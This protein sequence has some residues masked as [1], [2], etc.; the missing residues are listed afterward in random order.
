LTTPQ[1]GG[2]DGQPDNALLLYL[3]AILGLSAS[4]GT[5]VIGVI[6][7]KVDDV[8]MLVSIP[9]LVLGIAGIAA[10]YYRD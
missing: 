10:Y 8:V 4:F 3:F 2:S 6:L 7:G 1:S 9:W 5:L